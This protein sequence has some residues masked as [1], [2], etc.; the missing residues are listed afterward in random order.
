M[1]SFIWDRTEEKK[2][3]A[4]NIKQKKKKFDLI[5][6]IQLQDYFI[7]YC[8]VNINKEKIVCN[9]T[10]I[11]K[12]TEKGFVRLVRQNLDDDKLSRL[13]ALCKATQFY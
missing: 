2:H 11:T 10:G 7:T 8:Y 4:R 12:L 1:V 9:L 13:G 3:E 5:K 6:F